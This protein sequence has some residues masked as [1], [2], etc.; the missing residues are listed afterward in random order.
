MRAHFR[1]MLLLL[2]LL[3]LLNTFLPLLP[4]VLSLVRPHADSSGSGFNIVCFRL[5]CCPRLGEHC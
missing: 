3:L 5:R 4:L 1:V 2:L